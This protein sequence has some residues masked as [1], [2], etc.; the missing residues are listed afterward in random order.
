MV[1]NA[2]VEVVLVTKDNLSR[3]IKRPLYKG[4]E[5]LSST[6]KSAYLRPYFM[7]TY[8]SCY[9]DIKHLDYDLNPYFDMLEKSN[10]DMI[11]YKE[12]DGYYG[13]W[14]KNWVNENKLC[15][16]GMYI[17]KP[18]TLLAHKWYKRVLLHLNKIY[19]DL[20]QN[21]GTYHAR[22]ITG[23][24]NNGEYNPDKYGKYPLDWGVFFGSTFQKTQHDHIDK[25]MTGMPYTFSNH[26][27]FVQYR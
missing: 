22:A 18:N 26:K 16:C 1:A 9:A 5:Y 7:M 2:G 14:S 25:V 15:G 13:K 3:F 8:G 27:N 24:I 23:G 11:G 6:H 20:E 10:N 4:F 17:F 12:G 21:P 19:N